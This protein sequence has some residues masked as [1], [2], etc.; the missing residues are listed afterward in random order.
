MLI[1]KCAQ[2]KSKPPKVFDGILGDEKS[3]RFG[4]KHL[5]VLNS[6][7]VPRTSRQGWPHHF[8]GLAQFVF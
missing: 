6:P 1:F 4:L 5:A 7:T 8:H 2:H 3:D